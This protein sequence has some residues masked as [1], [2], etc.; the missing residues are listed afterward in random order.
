[1]GHEAIVGKSIIGS[2]NKKCRAP[3]VGICLVCSRN[4]KEASVA[5]MEQA[6]GEWLNVSLEWWPGARSYEIL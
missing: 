5:Q 4:S 6:K 1:M 2:G 3:W